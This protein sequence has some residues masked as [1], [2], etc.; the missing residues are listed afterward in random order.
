MESKMILV[1]TMSISEFLTMD[2]QLSFNK[3]AFLSIKNLIPNLK[4]EHTCLF[5]D[6]DGN[7][8]VCAYNDDTVNIYKNE[9]NVLNNKEN[10]K[11]NRRGLICKSREIQQAIKDWIVRN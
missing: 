11:E 9:S 1:R 6:T 8:Y 7:N 5:K 2:G 4:Y 10:R 3:R